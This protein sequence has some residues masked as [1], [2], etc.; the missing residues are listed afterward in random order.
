MRCLYKAIVV[1]G[2]AQQWEMVII[3]VALLAGVVFDEVVRRMTL[4]RRLKS[5]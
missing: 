2:I 5:Q 4:R 1:L 3:G